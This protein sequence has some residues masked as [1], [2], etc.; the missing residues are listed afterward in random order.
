MSGEP[1]T[2]VDLI[3]AIASLW[4]VV[5]VLAFVIVIVLFRE[6]FRNALT[7]LR[8]L[9]IKRGKTEVAIEK[10]PA[11]E[12][13]KPGESGLIEAKQ[14]AQEQQEIEEIK[15]PKNPAEW[16][17]KMLG[18]FREN[19][20]EDAEEAFKKLQA[21]EE[22]VLERIKNEAY[23]GFMKYVKGVG[24]NELEKLEKLTEKEGGRETVLLWLARCYEFSHNYAKAIETHK[25]ALLEKM[26]DE[27]RAYH[28]VSV[29]EDMYVMGEKDESIDFI[30]LN[31][32]NVESEN[33]KTILYKG[34]GNLYG[35]E[36][37]I[38]LKAIALQK[39]LEYKAGDKELLFNAAYAESEAKLSQL[40]ATNYNILLRFTPNHEFALNNLGVECD[41]L[42][43]P[44]KSVEY[45]KQSVEQNNSLAMANLGYR[46]MEKGFE[47]EARNVLDKARSL[48]NPHK[49]VGGAI[50]SLE[51]RKEK[52]NKKW[53]NVVSEGIKQQ[54]FC[55]GYAEACFLPVSNSVSFAGEWV[56]DTGKS[57]VIEEDGNGITGKW[58]AEKE[59]QKFTGRICNRS[60][61]IK[62]EE[63]E[64]GWLT[65]VKPQWG[66]TYKGL[67]YLS[68]DR[69]T[70]YV[71][72]LGKEPLLLFSMYRKESSENKETE[73][74]KLNGCKAS[75]PSI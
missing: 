68:A 35:K 24:S 38:I 21:S 50:S 13:K 28:A 30:R 20:Y 1:A 60:A 19:R 2:S 3:Q 63:K 34:I 59:G 66:K 27:D 33:A 29:G 43:M 70:L 72:I 11:E 6:A 44:I 39:G 26:D 23:Y 22:G 32:S 65:W 4:K 42:G 40:C 74:D 46:Y 16:F 55:W 14:E 52:E 62:Y 25:R 64:S 37:N 56:S 45:Y 48:E 54:Q 8:N 36:G 41:G 15:Q 75:A 47:Q 12:F 51:D 7:G 71:L 73:N 69:K 61:E 67:T 49:N 31:F 17:V 53:E 5:G 58:E 57:F 9:R 10:S 18:A